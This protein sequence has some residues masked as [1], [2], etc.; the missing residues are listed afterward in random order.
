MFIAFGINHQSASVALRE[1][2]AFN[3]DALNRAYASL[4][5]IE[6][7][8]GAVILST[9][10]RSE[11]YILSDITLDIRM[12]LASFFQLTHQDILEHSYHYQ[13]ED[14]IA[15]LFQ[16]TAGLDSLVLGEPQITGQVKQALATSKHYQ[17][18]PSALQ[19]VFDIAFQTAKKIRTDTD[20]GKSSVS[21]A[22]SAVKLAQQIFSSLQHIQILLVGAGETIELVAQHLVDNNAQHL[23]I[24]NRTMAR[25]QALVDN[26]CGQAITLEQLPSK[27][28]QADVV[29]SSTASTLPMIG[30]GMVENA[31][32]NRR[33]RPMLMIDLAVPRDI[34]PEVDEL[35]EVYLYTVDD[36]QQIIQENVA[37]RQAA[38][39]CAQVI[40]QQALHEHLR[41][42]QL[43]Q[44]MDVLKEFREQQTQIQDR[45][46]SKASQ[47]LADGKAVDEVIQE[48]TYKLTQQLSHGPTKL[49]A[50]AAAENDS[51][52]LALVKDKFG[53]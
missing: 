34:E 31:L 1:Q 33:H 40:I 41:W 12:W 4:Y 22:S 5:A 18:I 11:I 53:I 37:Q 32:V 38:A 19:K 27:L 8:Q 20:L 26:F 39:E 29:I 24:A 35:D 7:V 30:K 46:L 23:L 47:Q 44:Q 45:L 3:A 42:Q 10:N 43:Q 13:E 48:L 9:C 25:A 51:A 14:A 49:I 50:H 2:V 16:V 21:V 28:A 52:L 6:G 17:D 36:L 15:H